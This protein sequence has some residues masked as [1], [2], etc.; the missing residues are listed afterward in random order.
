MTGHNWVTRV[1][2]DNS[3]GRV[4]LVFKGKIVGSSNGSSQYLVYSPNEW[5]F[6]QGVPTG[7]STLWNPPPALPWWKT[8]PY[9]PIGA[10]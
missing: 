1:V 10:D 6:G 4:P 7:W 3:F 2:A 9:S 8:F 5:A